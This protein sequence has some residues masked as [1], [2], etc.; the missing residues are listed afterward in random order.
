VVKTIFSPKEKVTVAEAATE[1]VTPTVDPE[2]IKSLSKSLAARI[3][4]LRRVSEELQA[5][6]AAVKVAIAGTAAKKSGADFVPT[7]NETL[8]DYIA[9][10][11]GG[12]PSVEFFGQENEEPPAPLELGD[13]EIESIANYLLLEDGLLKFSMEARTPPAP[14]GEDEPLAEGEELLLQLQEILN[15]QQVATARDNAEKIAEIAMA[16]KDAGLDFTASGR[17]N[18]EKTVSA[19]V[20]GETVSNYLAT[21]EDAVFSFPN[22]SGKAERAALAYLTLAEGEVTYVRDPDPAPAPPFDLVGNDIIYD[23]ER[24]V[25]ICEQ[26]IEHA[27]GKNGPIEVDVKALAIEQEGILAVTGEP[28]RVTFASGVLTVLLPRDF[29]YEHES[30]GSLIITPKYS[31]NKEAIWLRL[32]LQP[33]DSRS[34]AAGMNGAA[35]LESLA[36]SLG[37]PVEKLG[38]KLFYWKNEEVL[39]GDLLYWV[40]ERHVGFGDSIVLVADAT[41][42]GMEELPEAERLQ[43]VLPDIIRSVTETGKQPPS[44]EAADASD[45]VSKK[46]AP[47]LLPGRTLRR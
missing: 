30:D 44:L 19:I 10:V 16:A 4:S 32:R 14:P 31:S 27:Q 18:V 39:E 1:P 22:L 35:R 17:R 36:K 40:T 13:V 6:E 41:A 43:A 45:S 28:A 2:E 46:P 9:A 26:A 42:R 25:S 21:G 11:I 38:D 23:L 20:E 12:G 33:P 5:R 8:L 29:L 7:G 34:K 37:R 3:T 24:G 15:K 47:P